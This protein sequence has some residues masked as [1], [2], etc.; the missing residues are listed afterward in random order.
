MANV[1]LFDGEEVRYRRLPR[2][3]V[4]Y[5]V[6]EDEKDDGGKE[7][8]GEKRDRGDGDITFVVER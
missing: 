4:V 1:R 6:G 7:A 3:F 8:A 5:S 2:G